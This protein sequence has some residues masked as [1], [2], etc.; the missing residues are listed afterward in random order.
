MLITLILT[1]FFNILPHS[2]ESGQVLDP[3]TVFTPDSSQSQTA[4]PVFRDVEMGILEGDAGTF[5]KHFARQI[6]LS[7]SGT[8][9]GYFSGNQAAYIIQNYFKLHHTIR[10]RL[11]TISLDSPNPYATGGGSFQYRGSV[12]QLQIYISLS[13]QDNRWTITQFNVY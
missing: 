7:L 4:E 13:R 3:G 10:F 11:T 8:E 6:S 9:S 2:P 1:L 12:M 5:S